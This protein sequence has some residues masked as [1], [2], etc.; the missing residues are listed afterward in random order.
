[1][2][3]ELLLALELK[4]LRSRVDVL[5]A[6]PMPVEG[7]EGPRGLQ[8]IK[9]DKGDKGDRG[10]PAEDGK[11]I[12]GDKGDQGVSVVDASI[13]FDNS[14]VLTLS[15]GTEIDAGQIDVGKTVLDS[16]ILKQTSADSPR[17]FAQAN[18]PEAPRLGDIWYDIS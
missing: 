13:D 3:K 9:G 7:K 16:I 11:S 4:K 15:D 12:K 10:A 5:V 2:D 1:M 17:V 8:G 14:L 6:V 18:P